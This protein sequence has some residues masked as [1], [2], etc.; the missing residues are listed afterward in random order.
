MSE[1]LTNKTVA[2]VDNPL[3]RTIT[4]DLA[5]R[6]EN[7]ILLPPAVIVPNQLSA[8]EAELTANITT[9]DWLVFTDR[10]CVDFLIERL[11][12]AAFDLFELDGMTICALG[13]TVADHLRFEQ[14][15]ADV[16]PSKTDDSTVFGAIGDYLSGSLAGIRFLVVN[17]QGIDSSLAGLLN[18]AGA[19][20]AAL[21]IYRLEPVADSEIARKTAL[22]RGGAIDEFIFSADEDLLALKAIFPGEPLAGILREV[23]VFAANERV[24]QTLSENGLRPLFLTREKKG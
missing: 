24:F 12:E 3:N 8:G 22:F 1:F 11:R 17:P 5:E 7:L 18:S 6:G 10:W 9:F 15:H 13:E 19:E 16:V 4:A 2:L 20:V 14:L 21:E 23:K